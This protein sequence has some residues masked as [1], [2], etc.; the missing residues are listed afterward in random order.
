MFS[1]LE[2]EMILFANTDKPEPVFPLS[3]LHSGC[4]NWKSDVTKLKLEKLEKC[5]QG[6]TR[7]IH[8]VRLSEHD[9]V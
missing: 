3:S 9:A 8:N 1:G 6:F 2:I 5:K 4:E 7:R